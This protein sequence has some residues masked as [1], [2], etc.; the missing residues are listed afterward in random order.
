MARE[1]IL[2]YLLLSFP[3]QVCTLGITDSELISLFVTIFP[4]LSTA[5]LDIKDHF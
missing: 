3:V 1:T 5:S 2:T 4:A